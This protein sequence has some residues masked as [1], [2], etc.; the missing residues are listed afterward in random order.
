MAWLCAEGPQGRSIPAWAS[1]PCLFAQRKHA[2][3]GDVDRQTTSIAA[4]DEGAAGELLVLATSPV[5]PISL[6]EP[7]LGRHS[8]LVCPRLVWTVPLGQ[9]ERPHLSVFQIRNGISVAG[10]ADLGHLSPRT[11]HTVSQKMKSILL[12]LLGATLSI[13]NANDSTEKTQLNQDVALDANTL[14]ELLRENWTVQSNNNEITLTSK[15]DVFIIGLVSRG[16]KAPEFSDK[17]PVK[18]LEAEAKP[19]KY[20]IHLRYEQQLPREELERRRIERQKAADVLNFGAASK[21]EHQSA[22]DRYSEIKVPCYR[23]GSYD[24][25]KMTPETPYAGV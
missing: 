22:G 17:T 15:F 13:L 14:R 12:L 2:Q 3:A 8:F 21:E 24:V 16:S 4:R 1:G 20:V 11:N 23:S 7:I 25:C 18:T 5:W 6:R 10:N 9:E 19:E